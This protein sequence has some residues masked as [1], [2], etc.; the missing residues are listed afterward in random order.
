MNP[1]L[2]CNIILL[3]FSLG[4]FRCSPSR[5]LYCQLLWIY[6]SDTKK[7]IS[8]VYPQYLLERIFI[9]VKCSRHY[10][11]LWNDI[12]FSLSIRKALNQP[13]FHS[14]VMNFHIGNRMTNNKLNKYFILN[15][16]SKIIL[17]EIKLLTQGW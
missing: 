9:S 11:F 14:S 1:Y 13:Q 4:A 15:S 12:R 16:N 8:C 17:T 7:H 3:L 6:D 2:L 10:L 5:F